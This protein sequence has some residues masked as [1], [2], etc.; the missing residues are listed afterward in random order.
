MKTEELFE[1]V[2]ILD[3]STVITIIGAGS[4]ERERTI[5]TAKYSFHMQIVLFSLI[6]FVK[7]LQNVNV[8]LDK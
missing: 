4:G 6:A 7:C 5:A 1:K 2:F 3:G 8:I